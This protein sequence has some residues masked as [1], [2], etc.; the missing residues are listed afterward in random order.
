MP[1]YLTF[2]LRPLVFF[3]VTLALFALETLCFLAAYPEIFAEVTGWEKLLVL[4]HSLP[5][6]ISTTG[7]LTI[8]P[9]LISMVGVWLPEKRDVDHYRT[10]DTKQSMLEVSDDCYVVGHKAIRWAI[11]GYSALVALVISAI[12]ILDGI[13]YPIWGFRLDA[14]PIWYFLS[15]PSTVWHSI[16]TEQIVSGLATILAVGGIWFAA[17]YFTWNLI[18]FRAARTRLRQALTFCGLLLMGALLFIGIRGGVT[19]STMNLSKA[20]FSSNQRL[21]HACINPAWSLMKSLLD[22]SGQ[23]LERYNLFPFEQVPE[24]LAMVA[25]LL[26]EEE[27]DWDAADS[28]LYNRR[29]D[30]HFIIL[31]SFSSHLLPSLGGENVAPNIDK[32]GREGLLF[33]EAYATAFRTDRA[34]PALLNAFPG[35]PELGVMKTVRSLEHLPSLSASLNEAD[36]QTEYYYGG[37]ANFTNMKA[38]LIAGGYNKIVSDEDFPISKR[39]GKWGALDEDLFELV[40]EQTLI[41]S[42]DRR[43]V[44]RVIQTSSSHE[45]FEVPFHK[46]DHPAKNAFAYTDSVVGDYLNHLRR[47]PDWKN[48]LVVLAADHQGAWPQGLSPKEAH[49]IPVIFTGGALKR[50]GRMDYPM[51]QVDITPT[52]LSMMGLD[53]TRFFFGR[54]VFH[55][56]EVPVLYYYTPETAWF[57]SPQGDVVMRISDLETETTCRADGVEGEATPFNPCCQ[58]RAWMEAI[59]SFYYR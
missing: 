1:P 43:P 58:M 5:M 40:K 15:A 56:K 50:K 54:N 20:Y 49:H 34:L 16:P 11:L 26:P 55:P 6:D 18:R 39:T 53:Q 8:V 10:H 42:N 2:L 44:L 7:Y 29:P 13:L 27:D 12:C 33:T 37:D 22:S 48:T 4:W 23:S 19:V 3:L 32:A 38:L 36:Y 35:L 25:P 30:I 51:T 57:S 17:Y 45:P 21:N 52:V 9:L 41:P 28:L 14:N 47:S 59:A 31:E 46:F 24:L